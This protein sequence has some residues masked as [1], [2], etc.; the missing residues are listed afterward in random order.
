M[1]D[2]DGAVP[3]AASPEEIATALEDALKRILEHGPMMFRHTLTQA[4]LGSRLGALLEELQDHVFA[5]AAKR[6]VLRPHEMHA[7]Q[8]IFPAL[9][10]M[11]RTLES[12]PL[13]GTP[14]LYD[15]LLHNFTVIVK[16]GK[17]TA[18]VVFE[19]PTPGAT[20]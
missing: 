16:G 12:N 1:A 13:Y 15:Q 18:A 8:L 10:A 19:K 14:A 11:A 5:P 7:Y 9:L 20:S 6:L 3:R 4:D 17:P 2:L